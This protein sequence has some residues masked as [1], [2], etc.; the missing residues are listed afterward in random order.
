MMTAPREL[1]PQPVPPQSMAPPHRAP[2]APMLAE[3]PPMT[4]HQ[5]DEPAAEEPGY[6]FGV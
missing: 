5:E 2:Q 4:D 3:P 6:G 1:Q